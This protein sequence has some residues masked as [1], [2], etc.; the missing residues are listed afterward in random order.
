MPASLY[1]RTRIVMG[2]PVTVG[3]VGSNVPA[4]AFDM[5][6]DLLTEADVRYSTYKLDSEVSRINRGLPE[7]EWSSEMRAVLKLCEETKQRTNGYFDVWHN[8]RLDPSGLVKGW[9]VQQAAA[10]LASRGYTQCYVDAGGDMQTHGRNAEGQPWQV[11]IRNPFKREEI[12]KVLSLSG[13]GVAT[14]GA[15]IR[16]DHIYNPH[17]PHDSPKE[18][19]SLTVIASNVFDADRFVTAAYAMGPQGIHFI[20]KL[21]GFEG[22]MIDTHGIATMTSNFGRYVSK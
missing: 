5:A 14:S 16:G 6:F 2:M 20:E 15:Y 7:R 18:I 4:K 3:I 22:Y 10:R 12:V 21:D 17:A 11:G 1:K 9:A 13:E 8:G 19:A